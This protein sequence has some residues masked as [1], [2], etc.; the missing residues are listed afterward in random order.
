MD[1]QLFPLGDHAIIIELGEEINIDIQQKIQF[2]TSYLD[3][4]PLEWMVEYIPAF[5]TIT[6]F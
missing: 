5:T 4:H 1:Y 3:D 6:I 2:I